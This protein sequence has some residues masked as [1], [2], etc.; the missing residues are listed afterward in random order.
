MSIFKA[1]VLTKCDRTISV[2]QQRRRFASVSRLNLN[3]A[4]QNQQF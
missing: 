4:L 2:R 3:A 1:L